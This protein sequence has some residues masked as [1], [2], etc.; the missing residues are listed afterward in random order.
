[1]CCKVQNGTMN[2]STIEHL[3]GTTRASENQETTFYIIMAMVTSKIKFWTERIMDRT[4]TKTAN[5]TRE[6]TTQ[7]SNSTYQAL[8][9][10]ETATIAA[11]QMRASR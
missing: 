11:N 1:M 5:D 4:N 2:A 10:R 6:T 3:T 9:K 8:G 7:E